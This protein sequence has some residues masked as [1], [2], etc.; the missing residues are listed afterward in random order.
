M[1]KKKKILFPV[2]LI[3]LLIVA[4]ILLPY[5]LERYVNRTLEDIPGY[6]GH[7]LDIDVALYRGAYNIDGLVL[8]KEN[9]SYPEPLL[10]FPESD[11]SIEW[12]ALLEGRIVSEIVLSNPQMTY[13]FEEQKKPNPDG[14]TDLNDWSEALTDLVP[15]KINQLQVN[16]GRISFIQFS[17]S[18]DINLFLKDLELTAIN[19]INVRNTGS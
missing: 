1:Y 14:E 8:E 15:I 3:V 19:L 5:F 11:I 2:L 6:T 4:R 7:V 17:T 9:S 18:P 13:I 10:F 12:S 16:N